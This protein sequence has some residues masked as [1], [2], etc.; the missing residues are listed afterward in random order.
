MPR[1]SAIDWDRA[2]G[3]LSCHS[4]EA[5]L[6]VPPELR[7]E[8]RVNPDDEA[9]IV[10]R[11]PRG[12]LV[13]ATSGFPRIAELGGVLGDMPHIW[14]N[15]HERASG[16]DLRR[17]DVRVEAQ[18]RDGRLVAD[19]TFPAETRPDPDGEPDRERKWRLVYV[20]AGRCRV[21]AVVCTDLD[22]KPLLTSVLDTLRT[23][24]N[25][26]VGGAR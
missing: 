5:A 16:R 10:V 7:D 6:T 15:L 23:S 18:M 2:N 1:L 12:A 4:G 9:S 11:Q 20:E 25:L 22:D 26:L 3:V 17:G 24:P 19:Y 21:A 14:A 13:V 8:V